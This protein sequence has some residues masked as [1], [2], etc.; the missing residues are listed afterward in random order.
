MDYVNLFGQLENKGSRLKQIKDMQK[1]I[2][3]YMLTDPLFDISDIHIASERNDFKGINL[4]QYLD[5]IYNNIDV[6]KYLWLKN[7]ASTLPKKF[8]NMGVLQIRKEY[9]TIIGL[10]REPI[11]NIINHKDSLP[12][13]PTEDDEYKKEK[14]KKG[15]KKYDI[16]YSN[17]KNLKKIFDNLESDTK[18][19]KKMLLKI[20]YYDQKNAKGEYILIKAFDKNNIKLIKRLINLKAN[21]NIVG[22]YKFTPLI[23][24]L[25]S[26]YDNDDIVKLLIEN[27]A[28]V[29][30]QDEYGTTPLIYSTNKPHIIKLLYENGADINIKDHR[31]DTALMAA[32]SSKNINSIKLLID[33]GSNVNEMNNEGS[34][35]LLYIGDNLEIAQ[36]LIANGIEINHMN[37]NGLSPLNYAVKMN[38]LPL[39]QLYIKNG[40]DLN[41]KDKNNN[42]IAMNIKNVSQETIL[43]LINH[44]MDIYVKNNA[45]QTILFSLIYYNPMIMEFILKYISNDNNSNNNKKKDELINAQN[46]IGDTVLI[47]ACRGDFESAELLLKYGADP[48]IRNNSGSNSLMVAI[49]NDKVNIVRLLIHNGADINAID[50]EDYTPLM[51]AVSRNDDKIVELL[52]NAGVDINAT[53]HSGKT[54]LDYIHNNGSNIKKLLLKNGAI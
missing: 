52:I 5:I 2:I 38:Y 8:N 53:N 26:F 29:N 17:A 20:T 36:L 22:K 49:K 31:G 30:A 28:N 24:A 48:N 50:N 37:N 3:S 6:W 16:I 1:L 21:V 41:L 14:F 18:I 45:G 25:I 46:S 19:T 33:Y 10:Y 32:C 13:D 27:G 34:N 43:F 11:E 40:A 7:I 39:I 51:I 23:K 54:A 12:T 42:T 44:G 9:V 35:A 15:Y 47:Q 4:D